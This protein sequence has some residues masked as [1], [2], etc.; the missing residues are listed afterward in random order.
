MSIVGY[1]SN[2]S[3][4]SFHDGDGIR[5]V[6]YFKGCGLHC[7]WC[8]NPEAI[9]VKPD[10]LFAPIKCIGCGRCFE[11]CPSCHKIVEGKRVFDR[12][13]CIRC[14]KCSD[15]CPTGALSMSGKEMDTDKVMGEIRKDKPYYLQ[16]GGGVTLSGGECLLQKDFALTILKECNKEGINTAIETALYVKK[17]TLTS[18]LPYVDTFLAD[19][20]IADREKHKKY[21][22]EYNDCIIENLRYI[23]NY[24]KKV[25]I[26]IPLIPT[27]NDSE[28]DIKSFAKIIST[29]GDR[30]KGI[31]ILKYNYLAKSKYEQLG[32]PYTSFGE[33]SQKNEFLDSYVKSLQEKV[34]KNIPV[35]YRK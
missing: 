21:I 25:L 24:A 32:Q 4:G 34:G 12:S 16:S 2:I 26:R 31:E 6:V 15:A 9:S 5:T 3:K 29:L 1:I 23:T 14:G 8:H 33:E 19:L 22:G 10:V 30:L 18:V 28:E 20:K 27:V 13:L 7:A 17:E 11:I 35:F